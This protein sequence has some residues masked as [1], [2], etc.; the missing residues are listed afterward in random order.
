MVKD[1]ELLDLKMHMHSSGVNLRYIGNVIACLLAKYPLAFSTTNQSSVKKETS[2]Q[3]H[4]ETPQSIIS[5]FS[6]LIQ[7]KKK[8]KGSYIKSDHQSDRQ[9][10]QLDKQDTSD[11]QP[12]ILCLL[13]EAIARIIKNELNQQLREKVQELM[14]PQEVRFFFCFKFT[15]LKIRFFL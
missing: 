7:K 1:P 6:S 15:E 3:K 4:Q 9:S 8:H 14:L 11:V 5:G 2:E 10:D 12:L 13:T